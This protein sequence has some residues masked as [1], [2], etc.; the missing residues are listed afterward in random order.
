MSDKL[1][2]CPTCGETGFINLKAHHCKA[3]AVR[4]TN[5]LAE[6]EALIPV[7]GGKCCTVQQQLSC[8]EVETAIM[9]QLHAVEFHRKASAIADLR[10]GVLFH[11]YR[12]LKGSD[13]SGFWTDCENTFA[14]NRATISRK[15]RLAVEWA[16]KSGA[17]E[18]T[19][20]QLAQASNLEDTSIP[21]VQLAF[22]FIGDQ[23]TTDLYRK[24]N[25]V[26]ARGGDVTPR[27]ASG[28]RLAAPRRTKEQIEADALAAGG[29]V[30]AAELRC[31]AHT[32]LNTGAEGTRLWD[33]LGDLDLEDLT[34]TINDLHLFMRG[35]VNRRRQR[36]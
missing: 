9:E 18:S 20:L 3:L 23:T 11:L 35:S 5:D 34:N 36:R 29:G 12:Q 33:T 24:Y 27:D 28:K 4:K 10:A 15:M 6:P 2:T 14:V 13:Y 19:I 32:G 26:K 31:I 1:L 22:D 30:W 17:D 21:A 16:R 25:L 7:K 8:Q